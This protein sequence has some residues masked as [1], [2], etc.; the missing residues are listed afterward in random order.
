[1]DKQWI[2]LCLMIC[3]PLSA[4][5]DPHSLEFQY[6]MYWDRTD[7][8]LFRQTT[9]L[10]GEVVFRCES[11]A[12]RDEPGPDWVAQTLSSTDLTER[13]TYCKDQYYEHMDMRR[14]INN[15]I[16]QTADILQR[17]R[18]CTINSSGV[19]PFDKW[20]VNGKDFLTFDPRTLKWTALSFLAK[21]V[22]EEWN[23]KSFRNHIYGEF[24][25]KECVKTHNML[26]QRRDAW[27][28]QRDRKNMKV[29]V[30]AKSITGSIRTS[31]L[32]QVT[33]RDLSGL[34]IQLTE[35]G[36]PLECGLQL[37]GPLPHGDGTFQIQLQVEAIVNRTKP[38]WCEIKSGAVNISVPWDGHL[39]QDQASISPVILAV[40]CGSC[41]LLFIIS[42]CYIQLHWKGNAGYKK[43]TLTDDSHSASSSVSSSLSC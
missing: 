3:M 14:E 21:P 34:R 9:L 5:L 43:V 36:L 37:T 7:Q 22:A 28:H 19:F 38:Y 13:D 8:L 41:F 32:C 39:L 10:D 17:S 25:Q 40:V 31:L 30:F 24:G 27:T 18:G 4:G 20:V 42:L 26:T 15:M 35:D 23:R 1:M 16:T 2:L 11:P 6:V 33:D 29:C 12:L